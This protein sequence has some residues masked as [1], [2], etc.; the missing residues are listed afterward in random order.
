MKTVYVG[1]HA[2]YVLAGDGTLLGIG[3]ARPLGLPRVVPPK[4]SDGKP[5]LLAQPGQLLG[6]WLVY[7]QQL[8]SAMASPCR[9]PSGPQRSYGDT[10]WSGE[11]FRL[12]WWLPRSFNC[13]EPHCRFDQEVTL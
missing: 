7:L 4:R 2:V 1:R 5:W 10:L 9:S 8:A 13:Y 12:R 3:E 11:R 6:P